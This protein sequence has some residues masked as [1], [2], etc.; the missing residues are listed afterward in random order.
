MI[1]LI[2]AC[3]KMCQSAQRGSSA[4]YGHTGATDSTGKPSMC[5]CVV[6]VRVRL[7]CLSACVCVCVCCVNCACTQC[8]CV[9][10]LAHVYLC[11]CVHVC[12]ALCVCAMAC[13]SVSDELYECVRYDQPRHCMRVGHL[14]GTVPC[15]V[16][17][18]RCIPQRRWREWPPGLLD[19]CSVCVCVRVCMHFKDV[20]EWM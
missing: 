3:F 13:V 8:T 10:V 12:S 5:V 14:S 11:M 17:I 19:R 4:S 15:A 9:D 6:F 2:Y 1:L 16:P 18:Y 20:V 7:V